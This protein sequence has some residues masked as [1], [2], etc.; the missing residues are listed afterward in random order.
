MG[1]GRF[2]GG[3]HPEYNKD[4]TRELG[5]EEMPLPGKL[6]VYFTQNLGAPPQPV[7]EKGDEVKPKCSLYIVQL[8]R[9]YF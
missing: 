6:I 8:Q 9:I 4:L 1:R 5:I 7:V 3:V 2:Y